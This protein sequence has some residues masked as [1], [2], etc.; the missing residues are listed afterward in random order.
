MR[1]WELV[2][3]ANMSAT[4]VESIIKKI[5]K[6]DEDKNEREMMELE[7][8]IEMRRVSFARQLELY[9]NTPIEIGGIV[10]RI[11]DKSLF[12][13]E[14]KRYVSSNY[15]VMTY[16]KICEQLYVYRDGIDAS[17]TGVL[18]LLIENLS[19]RFEMYKEDTFNNI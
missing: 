12:Y 16:P 4:D 5:E 7:E 8:V 3:D 11:N 19:E 1:E 2:R 15:N 9:R 14:V 18:E 10:C 17:R 13:S 6:V